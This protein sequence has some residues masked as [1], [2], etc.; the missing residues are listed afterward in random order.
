MH[1]A[2][3]REA[4]ITTTRRRDIRVIL[5]TSIL[6]KRYGFQIVHGCIYFRNETALAPLVRH[7]ERLS[8]KL[9]RESG[10]LGRLFPASPD[11]HN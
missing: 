10:I 4:E 6:E 2:S 9:R 5:R 11:C 8:S 3:N 7:R 1:Q